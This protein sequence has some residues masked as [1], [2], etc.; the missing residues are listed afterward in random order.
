ME[1]DQ[2]KGRSS[3]NPAGATAAAGAAERRAFAYLRDHVRPL[4]LALVA[5][6]V[7]GLF[8]TADAKILQ[9]LI[10][11]V[12]APR[13]N[14][15]LLLALAAVF[16]VHLLKGAALFSS[17]YLVSQVGHRIACR[18][19]EELFRKVESLPLAFFQQNRMGQ[20]LSRMASDVPVVQ[21]ALVTTNTALTNAFQV[22]FCLGMMFWLDWRLSLFSIVILPVIS[23]VVRR[24][25]EKLRGIG[26]LT[27]SRVGDLSS[28]FAEAVGGIREIQAFGAEE[29]E[30]ERFRKVNQE[31]YKAF[32]K[33]TKY[34]S[35]TSPIVELFHAIGMVM[36]IWVGARSVIESSLTVGQLVQFLACL[37][38]M[39]HPLRTLTEIQA[40]VKQ[41]VGA[42]E[43]IFELLDEPV[44]IRDRPGART[45]PSLAGRV[46][47]RGVSFH[48]GA[49]GNPNVL[50]NLDLV[51]EPGQVAALVG[52][53]GSGKSTF[54]NLLPRFYDVTDGAIL[55]DSI[56]VRDIALS[57]LRGYFGIVPQ[58]TFLFSGTIEENIAFGRPGASST[59]IRQAAV[60]ANA[61][62][63][64]ERLPA[65][66]QTMLG[67][68]GV[69]LSGGQRQRI[70]IARA[71]LKDPRILILDEATSSL[72]T[73]SEALVQDALRR[74]MRDRTTL[75]IA[76]RLSTVANADQIV[77][78]ESG[79]IREIG[80]HAELMSRGGLYHHLCRVQLLDRP[81][82]VPTA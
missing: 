11:D 58:E 78:L 12:L 55:L 59:Q 21:A 80:T 54:V 29:Q 28:A 16:V 39:F 30:L 71:L 4:V 25:S 1:T 50:T 68:R 44:T 57:C 37:G 40:S 41:A 52:R 10:D 72:D 8:T 43:R 53:S 66:F 31:S 15:T 63:F 14:Q 24:F 9:I 81:V 36:V 48:Y 35:L 17:R 42:A 18:L 56:D 62:E 7:V 20:I 76:H 75:V 73:E 69:N 45:L 77:V 67:E 46:E 79:T 47:Y 74:L 5:A 70:A 64:I 2:G 26:A 27:Q 13:S 38:M 51:L 19:R 60:D 82:L 22:L 23:V 33:A 49:D 34:T 6:A 32:M 65:G 3:G 61:W